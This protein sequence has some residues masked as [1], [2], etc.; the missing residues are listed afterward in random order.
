M[1][2]EQLAKLYLQSL[3]KNEKKTFEIAEKQLKTSFRLE[4]SIGYL[5]FIKNRPPPQPQIKNE[6][7][8]PPVPPPKS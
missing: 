2:N 4:K 6:S 7:V 5:N 3:S 1:D 8:T